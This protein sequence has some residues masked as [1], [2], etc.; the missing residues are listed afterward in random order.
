MAGPGLRGSDCRIKS[1]A[2]LVLLREDSRE[3]PLFPQGNQDTH[4]L[5]NYDSQP[6]QAGDAFISLSPERGGECYWPTFHGAEC[7]A[8]GPAGSGKAGPPLPRER[9]EPPLTA[10]RMDGAMRRTAREGSRRQPS[11][12]GGEDRK[13]LQGV[14]GVQSV[15][16]PEDAGPAHRVCRKTRCRDAGRE[17]AVLPARTLPGHPPCVLAACRGPLAGVEGLWPPRSRGAQPGARDHGH[18]NSG[19]C[20]SLPPQ[21]PRSPC[22]LGSRGCD[23]P[24]GT[25]S[26]HLA[27]TLPWSGRGRTAP[28]EAVWGEG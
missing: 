6:L 16:G 28:G 23:V 8:A 7:E 2:Q 14:E 1:C 22:R 3:P 13:C 18:Q 27:L 15:P 25:V 9:G 26:H 20:S 12:A 5:V 4:E 24:L 10:W 19:G 21:G 11:G 17:T